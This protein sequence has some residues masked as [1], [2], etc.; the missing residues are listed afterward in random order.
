MIHP[1]LLCGGRGARLWPSSRETFPK[2]FASIMSERS[3]FQQTLA[4]LAGPGIAAPVVTTVEDY[5]FLA[6]GQAQEIGMIDLRLA[7][8]PA[9][10]GTAAAV[11]AS[12]LAIEDDADAMVLVLP[13]DYARDAGALFAEDLQ[14]AAASLRPG[15]ALLFTEEVVEEVAPRQMAVVGGDGGA[16]ARLRSVPDPDDGALTGA[17]LLRRDDLI[18]LFKAA[19]PEML[20]ACRHAVAD[21]PAEPGVMRLD[22]TA[23]DGV[24]PCDFTEMVVSGPM[25]TQ[26]APMAA[27][28]TALGTWSSVWDLLEKDGDGV[29]ITGPAVGVRCR[30]SLLRSE[31]PAIQVVGLGLSNTVAVATRD[32]VL[33][34]DRDHLDALPE[35]ISRLRRTEAPQATDH[36]RYHRPWG[37]YETLVLGHRFQVKRIMVKPGGVLSLQSHVH[38]SEH[39]VVVGGSAQVTVGEEVRLVPENGSVYIPVGTVHRMAN[40]GKV[41]MYLIEVQTGEYLGEDDIERYEDIYNR[42]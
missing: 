2:Q 41:P 21:A 28:C 4:R 11:L 12:A 1:I 24:A 33:V 23:F 14:A 20:E 8:E 25:P 9:G 36:P 7:I 29:A 30:D 3:A 26:R 32:A 31:D 6:A 38:R 40:P 27:P 19:A 35:A 34:A 10:L 15:T 39:W 16:A 5:R 18:A 42:C 13:V 37:W 17:A 22:A